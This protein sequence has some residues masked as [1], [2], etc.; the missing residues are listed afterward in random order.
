MSIEYLPG[1][2]VGEKINLDDLPSGRF[3]KKKERRP[4]SFS[5]VLDR[6][7]S[8]MSQRLNSEY[9]ELFSGA[10][11]VS[12]IDLSEQDRQIIE[13]KEVLWA[14]EQNKSLADWRRDREKSAPVICEKALT[15]LFDQ[16][17]RSEF[18]VVRASTYDDYKNGADQLIIDKQTGAVICGLD[19]VLG[20]EGDDGGAKKA[21]LLAKRM[22]EG[23]AT[24]KYGIATSEDGL[25]CKS[26]SNVPLFYFSLS[27]EELGRL[28][29]YLESGSTVL[30]QEA[31]E[32]YSKLVQSLA[33]QA[34]SYLASPKVAGP[35]AANISNLQPS[36]ERMLNNR[37]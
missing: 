11:Q 31:Q 22:T 33:S 28:L 7:L 3:D 19:D 35:L 20:H 27:K 14:G 29:M 24:V 16:V 23:G 17:L 4:E 18:I 32:I 26:F 12:E 36:I 8:Q 6:G 10:G 5:A 13:D 25:K 34:K 1:L 21:S 37:G 15:L 30:S 9:G 2:K